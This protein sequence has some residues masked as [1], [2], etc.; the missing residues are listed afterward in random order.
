MNFCINFFCSK[1]IR[2]SALLKILQLT[3]VFRVYGFG[4][5]HP[6]D[7]V[8][9][10]N[11]VNS[12]WVIQRT[13]ISRL[14]GQSKRTFARNGHPHENLPRLPLL[15]LKLSTFYPLALTSS[16]WASPS[17][18]Q[19]PIE[20]LNLSFFLARCSHRPWLWLTPSSIIAL[21]PGTWIWWQSRVNRLSRLLSSSVK[22]FSRALCDKED[23]TWK[24]WNHALH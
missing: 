22:Q 13:A 5:T 6:Y 16:V 20:T 18:S 7:M 14:C 11:P 19:M 17:L 23:D 8:P 1:L 24:L 2:L 3:S 10:S 9:D 15:P 12:S 21:S 4:G